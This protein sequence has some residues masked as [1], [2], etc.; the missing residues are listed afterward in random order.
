MNRIKI[1]GRQL[2]LSSALLIGCSLSG[3]A[4][5]GEGTSVRPSR[6][7]DAAMTAEEAFRRNYSNPGGM[8]MP[9]Q[10]TLP[11]HQENFRKMGV[12]IPAAQLSDPLAHPLAAVVS[13]GGCTASFVS[14]DGLIVTN[15]HCVQDALQRNSSEKQDLV[16]NGFL[17][18]DR[19]GELSA[20]PAQR[21]MVAQAFRDVTREMRDGLEK[22]RNPV[23]RKRE[24]ERRMK[25]LIAETEKDRPG[26]RCSVASFFGDSQYK[27]IE[28][29]EIRDVRLVYAPHR[30]V[31]NFGG[32]I[33]NWAWPRHCGD[34]SFFR[35][36][37]G[38][39]G[40][41]E[42]FSPDNVPYKPAHYLKVSAEGVKKSDFV[43]VVGYPGR[44]ERTETAAEIRH[45][46]EWFYPYSIQ[47]Y[48]E[49][50]QI[51]EKLINSAD[52]NTAIKAVVAKQYVQNRLEK[53]EGVLA[54]LTKGDLLD[55]KAELDTRIKAWAAAPGREAIK[56]DIEK[57]EKIQ[58]EARRTARADFDRNA[59]FSGSSL[60]STALT[61]VRMAEE[62]PKKD[63]DRKPGFQDRD[64][65]NMVARQKSF[66]REY[67][68]TLDRE[69]FRLSLLRAAKLP[70]PERPW[71]ARLFGMNRGKA[72]DEAVIDVALTSMYE[73]TRLEDEAVRLDLLK[74]GTMAGLRANKDPFIKAALAVW[75]IY[76]AEE[77]ISDSREGDLLLV[78]PAYTGAMLDVLGGFLAPDANSTLRISYGTVR[79]FAP[80]SEREAD[81]PFTTG[82]QILAKDTGKEPFDSPGKLLEALKAQ[83]YGPYAQ[84]A[85]NGELPVDFLS[86]LDITNGNSGSPTLNDNGDL[87]G[88][89]F[90]GTMEGV[91]S[92]VVFNGESTRAIHADTRYMLWIMDAVDGA[93]YLVREMGIE[94]SL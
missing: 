92:D 52:K 13:L 6:Q 93:D 5:S 87:V 46:V 18:K 37:V 27:L 2:L 71:L 75:Q 83:R 77:K 33:D 63:A 8:W 34:F 26:I 80:D 73:N 50:Y 38:K 14:P 25:A 56:S 32:E 70:G 90:D 12:S 45:D 60:L 61:L 85:L 57:M 62:R 31:G 3:I 48:K 11:E 36:Y 39:D 67:D 49:R 55:R 86:D 89:A 64:M 17:A 79:S 41:P 76:K 44:T 53:A 74:N 4:F 16:E 7:T 43:M 24:S 15:H 59:A 9:S 68:R 82:A 22:I 65:N 20:G 94:P 69:F 10:M 51:T 81:W 23:K 91:A 84:E 28:Y 19:A 72:I 1:S 29:L 35:A 21:V 88:L 54:G 66:T 78:K 47:Y 40:K 30:A 42:D 58:A